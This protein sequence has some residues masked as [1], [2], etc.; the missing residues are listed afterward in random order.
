MAPPENPPSSTTLWPQADAWACAIHEAAHAVAATAT[1]YGYVHT[2]SIEGEFGSF[3]RA[4]IASVRYEDY[5]LLTM[6]E[7]GREYL[8]ASY[9]TT[10]AGPAAQELI[11]HP[12]EKWREDCDAVADGYP[13][14]HGSDYHTVRMATDL[15]EIS[16]EE[17]WEEAARL[18]RRPD[19]WCAIE[20]VAGTLVALRERG[21]PAVLDEAGYRAAIGDGYATIE[22]LAFTS[23]RE[24]AS[25]A[26]YW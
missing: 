11:G 6:S 1:G 24:A 13:P 2:V 21:E 25:A 26:L 8:R 19:V 14:D 16:V 22:A 18:V 7:R 9:V 12:C 10:A 4:A 23:P 5:D 20:A 3:G 17:A 15:L